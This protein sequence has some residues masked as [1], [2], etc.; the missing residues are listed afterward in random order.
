MY[1]D[2]CF[3]PSVSC[4]KIGIIVSSV[5]TLC[6]VV[7]VFVDRLFTSDNTAPGG[8][9][10]NVKITSTAHKTEVGKRLRSVDDGGRD[11]VDHVPIID[12]GLDIR[13]LLILDQ[14]LEHPHCTTMHVARDERDAHASVQSDGL[15]LLDKPVALGFVVFRRPMVVLASRE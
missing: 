4:G 14:R 9:H 7:C 6:I 1:G 12:R 10:G 2:F 5:P 13:L 11:D 8:L 15:E 3:E